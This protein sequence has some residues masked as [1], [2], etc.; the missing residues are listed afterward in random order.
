MQRHNIYGSMVL[1]IILAVHTNG[2]F[3]PLGRVHFA[4]TLAYQQLVFVPRPNIIYNWSIVTISAFIFE[5]SD[6]N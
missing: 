1:K 2:D 5:V 4:R 3:G 6:L